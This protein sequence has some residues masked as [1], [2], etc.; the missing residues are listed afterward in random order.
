MPVMIGY[1][2]E[3]PID[4]SKHVKMTINAKSLNSDA[5]ADG[6]GD[7]DGGGYEKE[8]QG[9]RDLLSKGFKGF[10]PSATSGGSSASASASASAENDSIDRIVALQRLKAGLCARACCRL[11]DLRCSADDRQQWG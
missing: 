7:G 8:Q 2:K 10:L 4:F 9:Y 11:C 5:D 6:D 1:G 3:E